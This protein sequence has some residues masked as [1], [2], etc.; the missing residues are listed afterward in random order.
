MTSIEKEK[1]RYLREEG[2]GYKAIATRL[3]L[4]VDTVKS[5]CKRSGLCGEAVE[6][7][8][9]A[10]RQCGK[11]LA[12][13]PGAKKQRFCSALCRNTWWNQHAYLHA[14]KEDNQRVCACCGDV[15]YSRTSR[16]RK[17]CGHACYIQA[18]FGEV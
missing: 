11:P 1:I 10:C 16:L 8:G 9:H 2:L 17:Y 3:T 4:S 7:A 15:V 14:P 6:N 13:K 12:K 18:R 5:F